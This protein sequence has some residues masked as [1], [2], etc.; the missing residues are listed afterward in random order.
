MSARKELE[1]F[2]LSAFSASELRRFIRYELQYVADLADSIPEG[3]SHAVVTDELLSALERRGML[4]ERFIEALGNARPA[5]VAELASARAALANQR[6]LGIFV[7][8]SWRDRSDVEP[9]LRALSEQP[10]ARVLDPGSLP[11]GSDLEASVGALLEQADGVLAVIGDREAP[12]RWQQVELGYALASVKPIVPAWVSSKAREHTPLALGGLLGVDLEQASPTEVAADI[13]AAV[14][15]RSELGQFAPS[16]RRSI[17]L[18]VEQFF[19]DA[20]RAVRRNS[21][22]D[23]S[24][25]EPVMLL[26]ETGTAS[27]IYA[28]A[29]RV[30]R[31]QSGGFLVTETDLSEDEDRIVT[32]QRLRG[33]PIAVLSIRQIRAAIEDRKCEAVL[34]AKQAEARGGDNLFDRRN[35]E[36]DERMVFGRKSLLAK[37]GSKLNRGEHVLITGTRKSGKTSALNVLR[38]RLADDQP[39]AAFDLQGFDRDDAAWPAKLFTQIVEAYDRW[40]WLRFVDWPTEEVAVATASDLAA[41]LRKRRQW[42]DERS[43]DAGSVPLMVIVLDELE[44]LLPREGEDGVGKRWLKAT[45][46]LRA[47]GQGSDRMIAIVAADLRPTV[48][49]RNILGESTNPFFQFFQEEPL[50]L[51]EVRAVN[52]MVT[53]LGARMGIEV[54]EDDFL[55]KLNSLSGGHPFIARV[56]A[57]HAV[58]DRAE[59]SRL[60]LEDLAPALDRIEEFDKLGS[61]FR[62]NFWAPLSDQ[63]RAVLVAAARRER[64]PEDREAKA[65]LR[66][67][68]LIVGEH[69]SIPAFAEWLRLEFPEDE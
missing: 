60:E 50:P 69:V 14:W 5:R 39:V 57:S 35:A 1:R 55:V 51:L 66:Y 2:V 33:L 56:I 61:F 8:Y 4:D 7:S 38:Q 27:S 32:Q 3:V 44:R 13:V 42:H 37:I 30:R 53:S 17:G 10:G 12:T 31:H 68:S 26:E 9:L 20:G 22:K 45:S 16:T 24:V 49:R 34:W 29:E 43:V 46:A 25:P 54:F 67:Q 64:L 28:L 21:P 40:G 6:P 47:V 63:E 18:L 62:A 23:W 65:S 41:A 36:Y 58:T 48:N 52:R 11:L 19:D 59:E 15:S